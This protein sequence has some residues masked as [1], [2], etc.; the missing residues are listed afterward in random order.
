M[1]GWFREH[2]ICWYD[3]RK[4]RC[5]NEGM[6]ANPVLRDLSGKGY[7]ATCYNFGWTADSG[8]DADGCLQFDGVNDYAVCSKDFVLTDFT[9]IMQRSCS[10]ISSRYPCVA[11][12]Y[13]SGR[14]TLAFESLAPVG[15]ISMS[16]WGFGKE[17]SVGINRSLSVS[18]M[19]PTSYNGQRIYRGSTPDNTDTK[20]CIGK[21]YPS[22][23]NAAMKIKLVSLLLL[24]CTLSVEQIEWVKERLIGAGS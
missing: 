5:T 2:V 10:N 18:Y 11:A 22:Q 14:Q 16:V 7:D 24:D 15:S 20:L 21:A 3:P 4:Q 8:I 6:A 1:P 17:N 12:K 19:T 13:L 9:I 23:Q